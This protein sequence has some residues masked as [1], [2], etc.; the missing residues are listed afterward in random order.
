MADYKLTAQDV[1]DIKGLLRRI[2]R[3]AETIAQKQDPEFRP[4]I[5]ALLK[6]P[7]TR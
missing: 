4:D 5:S 7:A 6:N 1:E 3:A 2:A